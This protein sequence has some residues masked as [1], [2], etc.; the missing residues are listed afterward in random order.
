MKITTF[1]RIFSGGK[2]ISENAKE[3]APTEIFYHKHNNYNPSEFRYELEGLA[4]E[5]MCRCI[6]IT[7]EAK[8]A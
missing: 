2:F 1:K 5:Q 7:Q 6:I 8:N 4:L 3:I